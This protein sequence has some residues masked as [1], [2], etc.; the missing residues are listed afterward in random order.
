MCDFGAQEPEQPRQLELNARVA[1]L[2]RVEVFTYP[3]QSGTRPLFEQVHATCRCVADHV[4]VH[5]TLKAE[6]G[7]RA[8]RVALGAFSDRHGMEPRRLQHHLR[9]AVADPTVCTAVD[10][11]ET[12]GLVAVRNDQILGIERTR[13]PVEG[14]EGFSLLGFSH[15]DLAS[16]N[17]IHVEGMQGVAKLVE[18]QIR[19]VDDVV[20]RLQ[21]NGAQLLLGPFRAGSHL[22][23]LQF[24]GEVMRT[25]FLRIHIQ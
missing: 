14:R 22:D 12:H 21:A 2:R 1:D 3:H 13:L 5:T 9:R 20:D 10:A 23:V 7:V 18:H 17:L 15:S 4:G 6:A 25:V 16:A 11:G 8:E 19:G 24:Q